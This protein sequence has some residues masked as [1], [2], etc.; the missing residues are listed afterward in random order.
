M[1]GHLI[2]PTKGDTRDRR[3]LVAAT[4]LIDSTTRGS[5]VTAALRSVAVTDVATGDTAHLDA[6][7]FWAYLRRRRHTLVVTRDLDLL[8][9]L[10]RPHPDGGEDWRTGTGIHVHSL[11]SSWWSADLWDVHN[12]GR[13]LL[14]AE[15]H[16]T[17]AASLAVWRRWATTHRLGRLRPTMAAQIRH[18]HLAH[19]WGPLWCHSHPDAWTLEGDA[20]AVPPIMDVRQPG[21]HPELYECDINSAYLHVMATRYLPIR[22]SRYTERPHT[23]A[24]LAELAVSR[25]WIADA[26]WPDGARRVICTP[27]LYDHGPPAHTVRLAEYHRGRPL[28]RFAQYWWHARQAAT[29][30]LEERLCKAAAVCLHMRLGMGGRHWETA[31]GDIA[32]HVTDRSTAV[33]GHPVRTIDDGT[34]EVRRDHV[35]RRGAAAAVGAEVVAWGRHLLRQLITETDAVYA[36]T[37][38]VWA[39]HPPASIPHGPGLGQLRVRRHHDVTIEETG[40]RW[41]GGRLD[42]QAGRPAALGARGGRH[43]VWEHYQTHPTAAVG[44]LITHSPKTPPQL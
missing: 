12:I 11:R 36:H 26:V 4:P 24:E 19:T 13:G 15:H 6:G 30:R 32:L 21:H 28:Q 29:T 34:V 8:L 42:A 9:A 23:A 27:E 44:L 43:L 35:L 33:D 41:I 5:T 37:D 17:L 25:C 20:R 16:D 18:A 39:V 22:L 40:W 1:T 10:T 38:C 2:A 14:P 31:P 7:E 3:H